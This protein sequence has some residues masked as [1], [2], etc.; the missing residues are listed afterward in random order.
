MATT[1]AALVARA[2]RAIQHRF[3][4]ADAVRPDRTV[5]FTPANGVE[6]RQFER[7]RARGVIH[8]PQPGAY[9]LDLPA[10]DAMLHE[11]H[12]RVKLV[13]ILLLVVAGALA[14]VAGMRVG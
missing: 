4:A 7:L 1:A 6:K 9:W 12:S 5:A 3:F 14:L 2:N 11:R 10:Y 13:A 8:E